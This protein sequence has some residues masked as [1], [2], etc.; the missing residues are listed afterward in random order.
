MK[1]KECVMFTMREIIE[2]AIRIEENGQKTYR[3][4]SEKA[5]DP[6]LVSLLQW[7]AHEESEHVRWFSDLKKTANYEGVDPEL[8]EMGRSILLGIVG[9]QAFSLEEWDLSA[10]ADLKEVLKIALDFEKDTVMFYEMMGTFVQEDASLAKLNQII[11]EENRHVSILSEFLTNGKVQVP[12]QPEVMIHERISGKRT[13]TD[14][15]KPGRL[16]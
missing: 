8:E 12:G 9:D 1:T 16:Q 11:R 3:E 7:L 14:Q 10:M 2:F 6:A 15:P 5:S 13:G 4:A